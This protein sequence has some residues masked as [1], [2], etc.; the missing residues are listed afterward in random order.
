MKDHLRSKYVKYQTFSD[1]ELESRILKFLQDYLAEIQ[2][3]DNPPAP[4]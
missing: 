4:V 1:Q 3:K 2:A